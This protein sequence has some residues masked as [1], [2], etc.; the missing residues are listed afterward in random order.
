MRGTRAGR[1]NHFQ[2]TGRQEIRAPMNFIGIRVAIGDTIASDGF[3]L[4]ANSF[5]LFFHHLLNAKR[6]IW[7]VTTRI[8][9]QRGN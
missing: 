5:S 2:A 7:I 3:L 1:I 4:R 9:Y 8:L 6:R